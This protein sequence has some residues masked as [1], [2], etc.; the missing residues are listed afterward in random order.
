MSL[1]NELH[2]HFES[3]RV[4]RA[5]NR[6]EFFFASPADVRTVLSEKLGN[7]LNFTEHAESID[8]LQSVQGW[9]DDIR[10]PQ[11]SRATSG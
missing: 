7:L 8:Y 5:N 10:A 2:K 4:N 9:P 3:R 11:P 1:E 6:K